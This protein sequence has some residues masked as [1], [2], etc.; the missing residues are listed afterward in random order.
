[1]LIALIFPTQMWA[2]ATRL[3]RRL[4]TFNPP[5]VKFN[6]TQTFTTGSYYRTMMGDEVERAQGAAA[7]ASPQSEDTIFGKIARKEIPCDIVLETDRAL[8]FRD[9]SPQ[10]PTHVLVI[11]KIKAIPQLSRSG[12]EDEALLG[13]LMCVAREVAAKENLDD[14]YRVV[15]NDG[16]HGAQSVYHLHLHVLGGRQ[17][18]WPPG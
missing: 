14:G 9:L 10:A 15:I 1:M 2:V 3:T 5:V 18:N 11:P 16:K 8:A 7:A 6:A 12:D 17:M 13:H 4:A